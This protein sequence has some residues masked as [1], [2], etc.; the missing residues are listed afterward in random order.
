MIL[1]CL[2][3]INNKKYVGLTENNWTSRFKIVSVPTLFLQSP[4]NL[5]QHN[6]CFG[7]LVKVILKIKLPTPMFLIF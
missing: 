4:Y 7:P 5:Y 1:N 2:T 6:F 3:H